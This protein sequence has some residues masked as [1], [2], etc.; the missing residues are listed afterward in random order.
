VADKVVAETTEMM[1]RRGKNWIRE[2]TGNE[3]QYPVK[4]NVL[5]LFIMGTIYR[6]TVF[7][8]G[9]V[10]SWFVTPFGLHDFFV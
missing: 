8:R 10:I 5:L 4:H 3:W 6:Q 7:L 1:K 2:T 9:K